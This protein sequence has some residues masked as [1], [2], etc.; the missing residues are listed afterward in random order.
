M[1]GLNCYSAG[2]LIQVKKEVRIKEQK[3]VKDIL[4]NQK[5]LLSA[6]G[7]VNEADYILDGH[8]CL[9]KE[10]NTLERIPYEIFKR[11]NITCIY[12]VLDDASKIKNNLEKRDKLIWDTEFINRFQKEELSYA[13]YLSERMDIPLKTINAN[14]K[15]GYLLDDYDKGIILPINPQFVELIFAGE[16]RYE[17][18]KK[19]CKKDIN[20]LYIYSTSPQSAIVGEVEVREKINKEKEELWRE[21]CGGSGITKPFY[22]EYFEKQDNS[23]AYL[24][25]NVKKYDKPIELR[26][27][28]INYV[29]Q[30]FLYVDEKLEG[31]I[32]LELLNPLPQSN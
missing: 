18:R 19:L 2:E 15:I 27:I 4:E 5:I 23:C 26:R 24:L 3:K 11:M 9:I 28:G 1:L 25:G 7:E 21:S 22:D 16:K 8:L 6:L 29:P 32:R 31:R 14:E 13:M 30:S 12:I 20:K 10:D 17:Y